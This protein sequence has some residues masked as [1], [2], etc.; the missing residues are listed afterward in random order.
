MRCCASLFPANYQGSQCPLSHLRLA[1]HMDAVMW[2]SQPLVDEAWVR[3]VVPILTT[4][5]LHPTVEVLALY[6]E[7]SLAPMMVHPICLMQTI[8][9]NQLLVWVLFH[10]FSHVVPPT[11]PVSSTL[12]SLVYIAL[13]PSRVSPL[14]HA[15]PL[16]LPLFSYPYSS[17]RFTCCAD[18][19]LPLYP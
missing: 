16:L 9:M 5:Y 7:R 4:P 18:A 12:P 14:A 8:L 15:T 13:F 1:H 19:S 3:C 11:V 6:H 2:V 10:L 17:M